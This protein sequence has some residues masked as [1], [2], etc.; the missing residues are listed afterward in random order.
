MKLRL[1]WF[2]GFIFFYREWI[3]ILLD[4]LMME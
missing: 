2:G 1:I 4:I 3:R